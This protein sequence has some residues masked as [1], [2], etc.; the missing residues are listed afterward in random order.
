[1]VCLGCL[2][3]LEK[4]YP[5]L[6]QHCG[7]PF[8]S[9]TCQE[10]VIHRQQECQ[11]FA[12]RNI[13]F[14]VEEN[15]ANHPIYRVIFVLRLL[16]VRDSNP[17]KWKQISQLMDHQEDRESK[18]PITWSKLREEIVDYLLTGLNLAD[19]FTA[20]E[21]Q[22]CIGIIRINAINSKDHLGVRY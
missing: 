1:M 7:L 8:C 9:P 19:L 2:K 16:L 22:K 15:S 13:R 5:Q 21:I 17:E 11:L 12:S 3:P 18:D 20:E 6:C 14:D 10:D 4:S